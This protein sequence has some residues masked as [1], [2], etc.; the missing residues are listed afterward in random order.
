VVLTALGWLWW[1]AWSAW[2]P[3][4]FAWQV[5]HLLKLFGRR[6]I[7]DT[8]VALCGGVALVAL[9]R[10]L[11]W[12][13]HLRHYSMGMVFGEINVTFG[14]R[15]GVALGDTHAAFGVAGVCIVDYLAT[16]RVNC[17]TAELGQNTAEQLSAR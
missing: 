15:G 9:G 7:G 14:L 1:R 4:A 8:H 17:E 5:R 13:A 12:Q 16:S 10:L 2:A 6:G 3:A 11:A